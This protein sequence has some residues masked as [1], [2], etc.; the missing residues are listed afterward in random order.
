MGQHAV[1][2]TLYWQVTDETDYWA[3]RLDKNVVVLH[4]YVIVV[5]G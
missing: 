5:A 1:F 3:L 4:Q 2:V